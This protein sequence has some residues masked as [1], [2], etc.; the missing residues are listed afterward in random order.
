[1]ASFFCDLD[2]TFFINGTNI[3][4]EGAVAQVHEWLR[5]GHQIIF[6]TARPNVQDVRYEL[7]KHG[8]KHRR[9]Q[10]WSGIQNPR[11]VVNDMGAYAINHP[12]NHPWHYPE[13][14]G[15]PVQEIR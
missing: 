6:T 2:G 5:A 11:V 4:N 14:T 10:L 3:P 8:L 7:R 9:V 13:F 1:M 12:K 15:L